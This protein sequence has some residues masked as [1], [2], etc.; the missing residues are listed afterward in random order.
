MER[1][2][3]HHN[4]ILLILV[5]MSRTI[6]LPAG[7]GASQDVGEIKLRENICKNND[8]ENHSCDFQG[9]MYYLEPR[10][11]VIVKEPI[12]NYHFYVNGFNKKFIVMPYECE[13]AEEL[14]KI[15]NKCHLEVCKVQK[16]AA[17]PYFS[18]DRLFL[19]ISHDLRFDNI[20]AHRRLKLCVDVYAYV[21]QDKRA[22]LQSEVSEWKL[23]SCFE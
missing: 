23:E 14:R 5:K 20:P 16:D 2:R 3:D 9:V 21:V 8:K 4:N 15:A 6:T 1:G 11:K 19:K 18:P 10:I 7:V 12:D 22:F 13:L 17:V